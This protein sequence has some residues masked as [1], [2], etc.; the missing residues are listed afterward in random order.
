M[1]DST[2]VIDND[3]LQVRLLLDWQHTENTET[4]SMNDAD[5]A[6][7]AREIHRH[8]HGS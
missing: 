5:R 2:I 3:Q 4:G 6:S 1:A 7:R 8:I